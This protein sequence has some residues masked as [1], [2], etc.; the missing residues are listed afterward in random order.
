MT[1]EQE[2]PEMTEARAK[3]GRVLEIYTP[4]SPGRDNAI[5]AM[6]AGLREFEAA[7][8]ADERA[9]CQHHEADVAH[10]AN[11]VSAREHHAA[12]ATASAEAAL[13]S[14]NEAQAA[15]AVSV[16]D[17]DA[18]RANL[19]EAQAN[20]TS[21]DIALGQDKEAMKREAAEANMQPKFDAAS[22]PPAPDVFSEKAP[23]VVPDE[24]AADAKSKRKK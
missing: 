12:V 14:A 1:P 23:V 4:R 11:E 19:R 21:G 24:P 7:I 18:M 6:A 15:A 17:A 20:G 3:F 9:R 13:K 5:K 22:P 2:S 8:R 10:R 16:V